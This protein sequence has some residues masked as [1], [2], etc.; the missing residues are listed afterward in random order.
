[1]EYTVKHLT[2]FATDIVKSVGT[3]T[4]VSKRVLSKK[5]YVLK[6]AYKKGFH[7]IVV[8]VVCRSGIYGKTLQIFLQKIL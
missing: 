6:N 1:M 3:E 5:Q 4:L 7:P 8:A 2:H